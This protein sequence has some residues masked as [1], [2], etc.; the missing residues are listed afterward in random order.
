VRLVLLPTALTDWPARS[1][2]PK[3]IEGR[4]RSRKD[5]FQHLATIYRDKARFCLVFVSKAYRDKVWPMHEL[6]QAQE[7]ALFSSTEYILPV[8]IDD[9][10]ELPGLNRTT[11]Y[12]DARERHLFLITGLILRKLGTFSDNDKY[13]RSELTRRKILK[14]LEGKR[15]IKF[16]GAEMVS[17]WPSKI[18]NAQALRHLTYSATVPRI[19]YGNE[20]TPKY[21]MR[22][23][24]KDCCV[25]WAQLH[26]PGCDVEICPPCGGQ[27]ISCECPIGEYTAKRF[28]AQLLGKD[29]DTAKPIDYVPLRYGPLTEMAKRTRRRRRR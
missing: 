15:R 6:R 19:P 16:G 10:V 28:E 25:R 3:A 4:P 23:N 17:T 24:C 8:L 14:R 13:D 26:V 27:L 11:G 5:L 22:K 7:R 2:H 1:V 9:E 20:M 12:V 18:M 21:H 29:E